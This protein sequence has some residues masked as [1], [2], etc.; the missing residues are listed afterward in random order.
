ML[1]MMA[2]VADYTRCVL[3]IIVYGITGACILS[4]IPVPQEWW[5]VLFGVSGFYFAMELP[6]LIRRVIG[7]IGEPPKPGGG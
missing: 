5:Y 1:P 3:A 2:L 4:S 7:S 6:P